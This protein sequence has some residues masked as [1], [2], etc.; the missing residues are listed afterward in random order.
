M[1]RA[2][3][4]GSRRGR[5]LV[6]AEDGVETPAEDQPVGAMSED[7]Y[8]K[9]ADVAGIEEIYR[10]AGQ[11]PWSYTRSRVTVSSSAFPM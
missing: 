6:F 9:G 11:G 10:A 8:V 5:G 3:D 7:L 4:A 2:A 1:K